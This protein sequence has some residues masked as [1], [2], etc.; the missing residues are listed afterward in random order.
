MGSWKNITKRTVEGIRRHVSKVVG[1]TNSKDVAHFTPQ[2]AAYWIFVGFFFLSFAANRFFY[3]NVQDR[4]NLGALAQDPG[5]SE[6]GAGE[7]EILYRKLSELLF[8][9]E[10]FQQLEH[11][12]PFLA[13]VPEVLD[14]VPSSVPLFREHYVLSSPYGQRYHPVHRV[15]KKHFGVDLAASKGT[16]IYATAAGRITRIEN[17]RHGHGL[18]VVIAHAHG[19]ETLYGHMESVAVSEGEA[20]GPHDFI[21]TVGSTGISTGPH[22]HYEIIK[23]GRRIDP[24]ASFDLKYELYLKL[25]TQ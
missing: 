6:N 17:A 3:G 19:F 24:T 22:L 25:N 11:L 4:E 13:L 5:I 14:S 21:G 12:R 9:M 7:T 16:P 18:H 23:N 2:N 1:V 15:T 8:Q 20:I 10:H